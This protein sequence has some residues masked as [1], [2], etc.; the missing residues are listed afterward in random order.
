M[1]VMIDH[2]PMVGIHDLGSHHGPNGGIN[3]NEVVL[4]HISKV[5]LESYRKASTKF[6]DLIGFLYS[7]PPDNYDQESLNV[8][9]DMITMALREEQ[10][11]RGSLEENIQIFIKRT[12]TKAT[13]IPGRNELN[14]I[15]PTLIWTMRL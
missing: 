14:W 3:N 1:V 9:R 8:S 12:L 10:T 4:S 7:F 5:E 2:F 6:P 11:M 13:T 15:K